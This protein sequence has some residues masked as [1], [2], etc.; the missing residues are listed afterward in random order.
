MQRLEQDGTEGEFLLVNGPAAPGLAFA[1][2]VQSI[3]ERM[4]DLLEDPSATE[5]ET[6]T[7]SACM[8]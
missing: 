7:L 5:T 2:L 1:G 3:N 6:L 8:E 4:P